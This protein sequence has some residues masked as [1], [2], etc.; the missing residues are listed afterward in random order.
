MWMPLQD[1]T[2]GTVILAAWGTVSNSWVVGEAHFVEGD[3]V[4]SGAWWWANEGPGDYHADDIISGG[5]IPKFYQP[6]PAPPTDPIV[7]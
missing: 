6:M 7:T 1:E 5:C 2:R 4:R 3:G